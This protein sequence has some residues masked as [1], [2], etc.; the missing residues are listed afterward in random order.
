MNSFLSKQHIRTLAQF[1]RVYQ[2]RQRFAG[3]FYVLYYR[4]NQE[5]CPRLGVVAS[6]RNVRTAVVR[7]RV[8]RIA[9]EAFRHR[10]QRL[11]TVDIIIVAKSDAATASRRDLHTCLDKLFT[12]LISQSESFASD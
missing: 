12:R 6:N 9:R 10:Q 1:Q 3:R 5:D 7:N 2:L 8:K 11:K 4:G